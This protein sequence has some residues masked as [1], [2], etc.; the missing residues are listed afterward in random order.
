MVEEIYSYFFN[1]SRPPE[2]SK[3]HLT[4]YFQINDFVVALWVY[5]YSQI[6]TNLVALSANFTVHG[7]QCA[8]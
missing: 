6:L 2:Y 5:T 3:K 8:E 4:F 1:S 7:Y